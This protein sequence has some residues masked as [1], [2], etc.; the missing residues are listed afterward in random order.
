MQTGEPAAVRLYAL[1]IRSGGIQVGTI[2][3][4]V[5]LDPY[6][7]TEGTVRL[8]S[9]VLA[10]LLLAGLYLVTRASVARALRPV[11]TMTEQAARWSAD[12]VDRRFGPKDRPEELELLA[13]TLD[14]V[15]DRLSAVLRHEQQ[16]TA[17]L[18]HELRT[19]LA[20]IL[21]EAELGNRAGRDPAQLR[22]ALAAVAASAEQMQEILETLLTAARTGTGLPGRCE[23]AGVLRGLV[24]RTAPNWPGLDMHVM[25]PSPVEVGVDGKVL[26]RMVAPLLDNAT[27]YAQAEVRLEIETHGQHVCVRV[28]DDGV[29]VNL[30]AG[31]DPFAPGWRVDDGHGGAGLGLALVRRLAQASGVGVQLVPTTSGACFEL[32]LPLG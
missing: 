17:E 21:A 16:L 8:A 24:D 13:V 1:P 18:S 14:G 10:V 28:V 12:D 29:G 4:S 20:R 22:S 2:V 11:A 32:V 7:R 30:P 23:A 25:A 15:L 6:A 27:R 19:P 26:E 9:A 5:A 3:S 31:D